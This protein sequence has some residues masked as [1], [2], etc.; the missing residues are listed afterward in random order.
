MPMQM[1][2]SLFIEMFTLIISG[3]LS[4]RRFHVLEGVV[5]I[6]FHKHSAL[7]QFLTMIFIS[8]IFR[9]K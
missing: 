9:E 6:L 3:R 5:L 2:E 8:F 4:L 1:L 7:L